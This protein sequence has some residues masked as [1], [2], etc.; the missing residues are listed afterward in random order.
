M[1]TTSGL[2]FQTHPVIAGSASKHHHSSHGDS[3][4]SSSSSNDNNGNS[5]INSGSDRRD[6]AATEVH[7]LMNDTNSTGSQMKHG[8]EFTFIGFVVQS[9]RTI[10]ALSKALILG[11]KDVYSNI[12]N[13][14]WNEIVNWVKEHVLETITAVIVLLIGS[15]FLFGCSIVAVVIVYFITSKRFNSG[16]RPQY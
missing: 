1:L 11:Q 4:H 5:S 6:A 8:K 10:F 12:S 14:V 13:E 16:T 15:C 7:T 2:P 9:T 3:D